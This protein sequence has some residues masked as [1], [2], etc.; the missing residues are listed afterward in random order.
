MGTQ[1]RKQI[2]T[3]EYDLCW[4]E[5]VNLQI[6]AAPPGQEPQHRAHTP[7]SCYL[8]AIVISKEMM[9]EELVFLCSPQ[10]P[11]LA[12]TPYSQFTGKTR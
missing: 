12:L 3:M 10:Q 7:H 8:K 1:T 2:I 5:N 11:G 4:K 6:N 9:L